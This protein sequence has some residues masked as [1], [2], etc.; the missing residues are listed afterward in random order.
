MYDELLVPVGPELTS[1]SAA[2]DEA[3]KFADELDSTIHLLYV[4]TTDDER[5]RH[6]ESADEHPEPIQHALDYL[7]DDFS[8]RCKT[9]S[10]DTA[11]KI[12]EMGDKYKVDAIVMGTN[13]ST[14]LKRVALGSVTEDVIRKTELPVV[15]LNY[16]G[17]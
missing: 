15:A 14:G 4:W 5:K 7:D 11:D 10:G 16:H 8:I 3:Y 17:D 1:N 9:E 2:L 6:M 13:A 12:V